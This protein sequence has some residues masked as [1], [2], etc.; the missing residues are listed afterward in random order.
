VPVRR[1]PLALIYVTA[2]FLLKA[3][4]VAK[5]EPATAEEVLSRYMQAIG[6]DRF[7]TITSF[8]ESGDLEGDL[9]NFGG[10][11]SPQRDHG[12]EH[13]TYES[14]YR[15][16]NL[17]FN[18]SM[19]AK[20]QVIGASGCDGKI[21]WYID[22]FLKRTEFKPTPEKKYGCGE[23]F[24]PLL[25][26]LQNAKVKMR[27]IKEKELDGNM[28]WEIKVNAPKTPDTETYYFDAETFLLV[29]SE[30]MGR[31]I[32]YS[33]YRDLNGI[34]LP[35][36]TTS[37][38]NDSR[39]VTIV[40]EL[41]IN[42]PIDGA[43]F[44]EPE[45]KGRS[46]DL[47]P[48]APSE[49]DSTAGI[50]ASP[51]TTPQT[52]T[53]E[54]S[55]APLSELPAA[56]KADSIVEVNFPNFT[57]C[58]IEELQQTVV[59]LKGLKPA[60]SQEQLAN[61]L[62]KVGARTLDIARNT[63]NLISR[64]TVIERQ[65]G[66]AETRHDFDYLILARIEGKMV[67]LDEF[68]VDVKSGEKFQT[69]E[70]LKKES[71]DRADLEH[72]SQQLAETS[73]APISQGF[74]TSWVHFYPLNR[75]R[76]T[77]RYLGEQKMDGRHTLVLAFAQNPELVL[78]PAIFSYQGKMVPMYLQGVAWVDASDFRILRL[79]TDL[80]APIPE[81]SLHRL[82]ADIHFGLT[83]IENVLSPLPLPQE[84]TV[85]STVGATTVSEI[86]KY[87]EYRLFRAQSRIV[88]VP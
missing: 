54:K 13:G 39:L 31:R 45:V 21:S 16:P 15:S 70:I 48:V 52:I 38:F 77:Y 36:K 47:N 18:S 80:L 46:V 73:Q 86:H 10:Y 23:G 85:T 30:F 35:F 27:L 74:A 41:K 53:T 40:R 1:P 4:A 22:A 6:A 7:S 66:S 61:L 3:T 84:V 67:D 5:Q 17:R 78:S 88:P 37:E 19:T 32:S 82:T 33:D 83:Q 50:S 65:Q 2:L 28:V 8:V 75:K 63:P 57:N 79:R 51:K 12:K 20:N 44:A 62:D 34:K 59:E 64:E 49:K 76:A 26:R 43:R 81:V 29:R 9:T 72:A 69:E 56:T 25:S 11:H 58:P 55:K 87:S 68:R 24:Q 42:V 71:S 60:T 14:Y